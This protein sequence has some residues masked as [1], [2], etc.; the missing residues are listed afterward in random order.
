MNAEVE[1]QDV[2]GWFISLEGPEGGGKSTQARRLADWLRAAGHEVVSVREPGG[3]PVGEAIRGILQHDTAGEAPVPAAET[4]LFEASRAQLAAGVIAPAL[5]A[6]RTVVCDRYADST[7]AYQGYGRGFDIERLLALHEF[8]VN[9]VTPDLTVLVDVPV[10]VGFAR[11][12]ARC[13]E[14]GQ[15]F[16]RME[17]EDLAFHE[18]VRNGYL[19]LAQRFPDRIRVVDGA[20]ELERVTAAVRDEVARL[21]AGAGPGEHRDG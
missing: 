20:G 16:D 2:R 4:L 15:G 10:A 7:T 19:A 18:R 13:R 1:H 17:C 11:L 21:L 14:S 3:T 8:A 6:G 5:A 9:G 12:Q